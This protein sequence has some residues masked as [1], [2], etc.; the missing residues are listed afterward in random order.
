[1]SSNGPGSIVKTLVVAS[2]PEASLWLKFF[3]SNVGN[4]LPRDR[5]NNEFCTS[6]RVCTRGNSSLYR[7]LEG[8]CMAEGKYALSKEHHDKR[9][10]NSL[11]F[12]IYLQRVGLTHR[13]VPSVGTVYFCLKSAN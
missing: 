6:D 7:S 8:Q 2:Q 12:N 10:R 13:T 3:P 9:R 4:Y 1:M 11:V 5:R